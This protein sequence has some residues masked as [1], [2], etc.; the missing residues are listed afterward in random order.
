MCLEAPLEAYHLINR[1]TIAATD[2]IPIKRIVVPAIL[3]LH[4]SPHFI[5]YL[6]LIVLTFFPSHLFL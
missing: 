2:N 5:K 6:F 4:T 3:L 1:L